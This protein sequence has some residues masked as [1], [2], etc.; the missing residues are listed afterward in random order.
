MI[1]VSII[2][3][4]YN[5][6]ELTINCI[7]SI[8]SQ[9]RNINYEVIVVDNASTVHDAF[10]LKHKFPTIVLIKSS[11]NLGFA[12]GNN[13]GIKK[14][15]GKYILLL[16]S[17]IILKENA[18]HTTFQFM[19][20][21][22]KAGVVSARL[23]F[24]DGKLQSVCQRFPSIKYTLFQLFRIQKFFNKKKAG[25]ILLGSFFDQSENLQVDWIW[26][27]YFMFRREII[28]KLPG[29]KLNDSYF[30]YCEDMQ[31]CW[32]IQK[33]DY[34]VHFCADAEVVHLMGGSNAKKQ[35]MMR[36]NNKIFRKKNYNNVY[37]WILNQLENCL[38]YTS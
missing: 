9:T 25:K 16:N 31:W 11:I 1:D 4:H 24:P 35:E 17:D 33:L 20:H 36:Q 28:Y 13:L 32:D 3:V 21:R 2:I 29:K 6:P 14:A 26:G 19:E 7:E 38:N 8:Y 15:K 12:G 22:P 18:I 27:A 5:T 34:K 10:D 30:M 37:S 23:I